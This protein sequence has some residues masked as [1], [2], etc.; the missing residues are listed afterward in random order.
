MFRIVGVVI[1]SYLRNVR[2]VSR[3]VRVVLSH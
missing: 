1:W 3:V 2:V